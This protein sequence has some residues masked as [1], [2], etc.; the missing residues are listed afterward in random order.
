MSNHD[1]A[2]TVLLREARVLDTQAREL[3][4]APAS[5]AAERDL[6]NDRSLRCR[7]QA[8]SLQASARRLME[9]E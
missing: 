1:A 9:A 2:I 7:D 5:V 3:E 6:N 8:L 4:R